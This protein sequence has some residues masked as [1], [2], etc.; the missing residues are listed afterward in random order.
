MNTPGMQDGSASQLRGTEGGAIAPI[1]PHQRRTDN[2]CIV[3]SVHPLLESVLCLRP[4]RRVR[5][6]APAQPQ[7]VDLHSDSDVTQQPHQSHRLRT[8]QHEDL[9]RPQVRISV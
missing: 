1:S 8:L 3:Y 9:P 7:G 2:I 4:A 5:L 6:A